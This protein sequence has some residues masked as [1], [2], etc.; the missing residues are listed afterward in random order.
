M[1][2]DATNQTDTKTTLAHWR[3]LGNSEKTTLL[4]ALEYNK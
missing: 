4:S 1:N 2:W 3:K